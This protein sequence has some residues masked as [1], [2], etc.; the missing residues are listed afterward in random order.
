G[1]VPVLD[2]TA[3]RDEESGAVT[4]F[5]VNRDQREELTLDVDLRACPGLVAGEHVAIP[6]A[7]PDAVNT[8]DQPDRV[9]PRPGRGQGG[10]LPRQGR[11]APAVLEHDPAAG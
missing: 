8:V 2:L 9:A 5:A 7:E 11:A 10:R 1:E 6:D 3:V 4:L